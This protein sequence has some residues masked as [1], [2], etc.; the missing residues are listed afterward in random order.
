MENT[1]STSK[2]ILAKIRKLGLEGEIDFYFVPSAELKNKIVRG[3]DPILDK[4]PF[5]AKKI[6]LEL[7]QDKGVA[8][9]TSMVLKYI[10]GTLDKNNSYIFDLG[11]IKI[12][13][14]NELMIKAL[15]RAKNMQK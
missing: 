6:F 14:E 4:L 13:N 8:L 1:K 12:H 11:E 15:G 5:L 2:E 3:G 10:D 9:L 7:P